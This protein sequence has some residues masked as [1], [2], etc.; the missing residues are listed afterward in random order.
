MLNFFFRTA[1][2]SAAV[3]LGATISLTN[4]TSAQETAK[5]DLVLLVADASMPKM[6]V[7]DGTVLGFISEIA[8]E[9]V[10]R[11]GYNPIVRTS[12]WMRAYNAAK[13]AAGIIPS[14]SYTEERSKIFLFSKPMYEDRV[15]L[16][17]LAERN[18]AF[19]G[20]KDLAGLTIGNM[21]GGLY[22]PEFE[23]AIPTFKMEED[24]SA[25]GRLRKLLAKRIDGAI[26]GG[27]LAAVRYNTELI[28]ADMKALTIHPTPLTVDKNHF[29]VAK[30]IPNAADVVGRLDKALESMWADGSIRQI[31]ARYE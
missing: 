30:A 27:G 19:N 12:P 24:N 31:V 22:G 4:A 23:A 5:P 1:A 10:K 18:L 20:L 21:R 9:A 14:L 29:G 8:I 16:V 13:E 17:T 28:G 3:I 26:M 6:Y 15:L 2:L 7:K 25:D 11:A